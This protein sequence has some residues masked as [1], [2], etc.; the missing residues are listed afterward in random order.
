MISYLVK[1]ENSTV[2]LSVM[3]TSPASSIA[4]LT[5][6]ENTFFVVKVLERVFHPAAGP[7]DRALA[8]VIR[9]L[10]RYVRLNP[11]A[12][13]D[14]DLALLLTISAALVQKKQ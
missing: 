9:T 8:A 2:E 11:T 5:P 12:T 6:N 14:E 3:P 13:A 7:E 4:P 1:K 10:A